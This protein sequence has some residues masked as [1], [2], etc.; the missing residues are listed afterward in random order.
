ML[1]TTTSAR[2]LSIMSQRLCTRAA[3]LVSRAPVSATSSRAA[4]SRGV[5]SL[6]RQSASCWAS[7]SPAAAVSAR[8]RAGVA[9]PQWALVAPRVGG[10]RRPFS[11]GAEESG[12]PSEVRRTHARAASVQ[13]AVPPPLHN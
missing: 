4:S 10:A 9:V 13:V 7:S 11:D 1:H 12:T 8:G 3:L 2:T 5:S 6:A